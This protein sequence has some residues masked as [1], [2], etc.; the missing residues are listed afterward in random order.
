M[1][2]ED[3]DQI[4][5]HL[6]GAEYT[7]EGS[8][9]AI[10]D[11]TIFGDYHMIA[12]AGR[13]RTS[14]AATSI[15]MGAN[16]DRAVLSGLH[17]LESISV[18][19]DAELPAASRFTDFTATSLTGT[20]DLDIRFDGQQLVTSRDVGTL[21][22]RARFEQVGDQAGVFASEALTLASDEA[23][24]IRLANWDNLGHSTAVLEIDRGRDGTI[25]QSRVLQNKAFRL[26]L[27][28]VY[29]D[30]SSTPQPPAYPVGDINHDEVSLTA[31]S[32]GSP[33]CHIQGSRPPFA[34]DRD[35]MID[36]TLNSGCE[37]SFME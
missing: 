33:S 20:A 4:A 17:N 13:L 34:S 31:P 36:H 3:P 9:S 5:L 6:P 18:T 11:Y 29:R 16:L 35:T 23:H 24:T 32:I 25:D 12:V 19:L 30:F 37:R 21:T 7:L 8:N 26:Y 10:V 2:A 14:G 27:P 22:Y 15:L 28:A 1:G